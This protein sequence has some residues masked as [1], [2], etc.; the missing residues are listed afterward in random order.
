MSKRSFLQYSFYSNLNDD[1]NFR[2]DILLG[3]AIL[4][5]ALLEFDLKDEVFFIFSDLIQR[6]FHFLQG[7]MI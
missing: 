2:F 4:V 5:F 6:I 7:L 3:G 1:R